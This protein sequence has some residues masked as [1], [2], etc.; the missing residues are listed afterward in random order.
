MIACVLLLWSLPADAITRCE[1]LARAQ[2]WVNAKVPYNQSGWYGGY[3][4][5]CSGYV[6]M[7]WKLGSSLVTSTLYKSSSTLGSFNHLQPGD[8]VNRSCCHVVLFKKWVTPGVSFQAYEHRN[9]GTVAGIYTW[10]V[11]YAKSKGYVPI[12]RGGITGCAPANKA[13]VGYLDGADSKCSSLY[14]WAQD[15]DSPSKALTVHVYINGPAGAKGALGLHAGAANIHRADLCKA[16]KSCKHGFKVA[17]PV[18][19]R[20]NKSHKAY[21]YTFDSKTGKP[22]ALKGYPRT[23]KCPPPAVPL[24]PAQARRRWVTG[25][26]SFAKWKLSY[27]SVYHLSTSQLAAYVLGQ[28]MPQ[29]PQLVRANGTLE[30]WLLDGSERRHVQSPAIMS[31]W[32]FTSAQVQLWSKAQVNLYAKG[33]AW[34]QKRHVVIEPGGGVFV[35]DSIPPVTVTPSADAGL[36]PQPDSGATLAPDLGGIPAPD[37]GAPW[38]DAGPGAAPDMASALP[39][40]PPPG[41]DLDGGCATGHHGGS[42]GG[43]GCLLVLLLVAILRR[44]AHRTFSGR[45]WM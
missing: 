4:T 17:I 28:P 41:R 30:V 8:A 27:Y 20:D 2:V 19:L 21:A 15:P 12:R 39:V 33:R 23:F 26:T 35:L 22:T 31:A 34:P 5:D 13:P 9:W 18:G 40:T 6:S 10:S 37:S 7:A 45:H 11:S 38:S 29:V 36:P 32:G 44:C 42:A 25:P 3:R 14:G 24:G 1:V 43:L 16:I